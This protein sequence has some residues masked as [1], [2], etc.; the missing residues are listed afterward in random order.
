M[1]S[2]RSFFLTRSGYSGIQ[3]WSAVWTG[4]NQSLWEYLEISLPMLC[5]LGLSGV[6]FVG[7]DIGGFAGN[8]TP[9][10]FARW[11]QIGVFYPLMRSHSRINTRPHLLPYLYSLFWSAASTG[12]PILRPM[13][14]HY[15]KDSQ[16]YKLYDQV[17][18]GSSLMA[19]PIYRPGIECRSV[20]FPIV[21]WYDWWTGESCIGKGYVLAHAPLEGMRIYTFVKKP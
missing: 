16:T 20:Y 17:L 4:D 6:P 1:R 19:A 2:R 12:E 13:F 3:E 5:N 7:A 14:H 8:S 10:L 18:L 15:F 9:E 21:T 11:M